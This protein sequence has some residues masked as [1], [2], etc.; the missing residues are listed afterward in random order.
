MDVA[1]GSGRHLSVLAAAGFRPFGVDISLEALRDARCQGA[2]PLPVW[3]A[4]L[5]RTLL[6]AKRFDLVLVTRYLERSLFP[7]LKS[8]VVPGGFVVYETFTCRQLQHDTGPRS[9]AHL[10]EFGELRHRFVHARSG[11]KLSGRIDSPIEANIDSSLGPRFDIV[12]YEECDA[13]EAVARLVARR[14]S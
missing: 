12:F 3:C 9:P 13:P 1:T 4:D 10:L 11:W 14:V 5:T 2:T 6:P 7:A 8:T